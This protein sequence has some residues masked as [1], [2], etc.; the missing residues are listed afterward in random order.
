MDFII[1]KEKIS[2]DVDTIAEEMKRRVTFSDMILE[3]TSR[4]ES[5]FCNWFSREIQIAVNSIHAND[6]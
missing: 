4:N 1:D 3:Y 5:E 2:I 6:F